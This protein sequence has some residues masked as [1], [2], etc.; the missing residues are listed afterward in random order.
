MMVYVVS[1]FDED[2][3]EQVVAVFGSEADAEAFVAAHSQPWVR[4][5]YRYQVFSVQ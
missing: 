5:E 1:C 3:G 4:V 2:C